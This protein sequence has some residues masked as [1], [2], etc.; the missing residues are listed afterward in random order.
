V[1]R[2]KRA[3]RPPVKP[4][5]PVRLRD[6]EPLQEWFKDV[7]GN[8]Y[9]VARLI[10]DAKDLPVFEVPLAALDLSGEI[11]R[12][13]CMRQLALHVRKCMQADLNYPIL[14]AWDGSIADGRHRILKAIA[15]G[16]RTILARRMTWRPEP[17]K[18][19]PAT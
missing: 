11:W 5:P 8:L 7:N 3:A 18:E 4:A 17:D 16:K 13:C 10:D 15:Q 12:G 1:K 6:N 14:I 19:A 2:P 9:A